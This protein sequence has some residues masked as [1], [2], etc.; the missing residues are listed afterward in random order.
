MLKK[1][2][3]AIGRRVS[4]FWFSVLI[5]LL[6]AASCTTVPPVPGLEGK[7]QA[8]ISRFTVTGIDNEHLK[9]FEAECSIEEGKDSGIISSLLPGGSGSKIMV[10][11]SVKKG[12]LWVDGVKMSRN[13]PLDLS[14][15]RQIQAVDRQGAVRN[16]SL[17][18]IGAPI[19]TFYLN[20]ENAAPILTKT[21]WVKGSVAIAGG[22]TA[23]SKPLAKVSMK[24]RGRGNS[25]WGMPKKPYRFT[26][27]ESASIFGLPKAKKWVLLANYADKSL[28]RNSVAYTVAA[29]MDALSFA[30]HQYPVILSLNG[31]YQGLYTLGEQIETG[32]GRVELEKPDDTAATSWFL[33]VNM[34]IDS[35]FEGGVE[36]KDFFK[37]PSGV[38][39]EY[40]T[41]DTDV[42]TE[43]QK[44]HIAAHVSEVEKAVLSGKG[45]AEYIN[46]ASFIDWLI[47]EELFKNQDSIF[48]S[49]VFLSRKKGGKISL[50]PIWDFDLSAGNSDYGS[51]G[52][53]PVKSPEGFFALY[54]EWFSGLYRDHDFR[55]S[56]AARWRE[57][58]ATLESLTFR[59]ID[60]HAALLAPLEKSNFRL[61]PIMGT[62]V[63]PNPPELVAIKTHAGQVEAYRNWM[64]ARFAWMDQAMD[65][66]SAE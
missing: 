42:I 56:V 39:F 21:D 27:D 31:V 44:A 57:K 38:K 60:E 45:Y 35:E 18:I 12:S 59:S 5:L 10:D 6:V 65:K 34:R 7:G 48:L 33:E 22:S 13:A 9:T 26:L 23:W 50:G 58:R 15:V 53:V 41:P 43:K 19:P 63:W 20:T 17:N 14:K 62:Y 1:I 4:L 2:G 3:C 16:Y 11:W 8:R 61:W 51:I 37:S 66:M 64:K 49:S 52:N 55:K 24:V 29:T 47:I 28:M 25:T 30:P 46:T 40:K 54:S 32:S 36:G